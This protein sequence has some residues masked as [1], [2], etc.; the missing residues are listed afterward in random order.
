M[1]A[2]L[3]F[4]RPVQ[5][6]T[7]QIENSSHPWFNLFGG[8]R[9]TSSGQV[10]TPSGSM[11]SAAV[12]LCVTFL[13]KLMASLAIE[14]AEEHEHG[15]TILP[16][17]PIAKLLK[18]K[19]NP[20]MTIYDFISLGM[21]N[22]A[23]NGN[24]YAELVYDGQ[25]EVKEIWPVHPD[26]LTI[27]R[28]DGHLIYVVRS[29]DG[30]VP[31]RQD[32]MIHIKWHSNDGINGISPIQHASEVV[33]H[34]LALQEYGSSLMANDA[35]PPLMIEVPVGLDDSSMENAKELLAS[36]ANRGTGKNRHRAGML[37]PGMKLHQLSISNEQVQ[38]LQSRQYTD[39]LI[40]ALFG[41]PSVYL[42][43]S[44]KDT[45]ASSNQKELDLRKYTLGP[46]ARN[47]ELE[48]TTKLFPNSNL[49]AR[50]N[51][52]SLLRADEKTR[53]EINQTAIQNGW[54]S[55]NEVRMREGENPVEGLDYYNNTKQADTIIPGE[56]QPSVDAVAE[57]PV[58]DT[59]SERTTPAIDASIY[60]P[61]VLDAVN[62][63]LTK[64][65]RQIRSAVK[66]HSND[67]D[68]F[69]SWVGKHYGDDQTTQHDLTQALSAIISS[70][71]AKG[72][73]LVDAD[74]AT[75]WA[76]SSKGQLMAVVRKNSDWKSAVNDCLNDWEA[77][78]VSNILDIFAKPIETI[79]TTQEQ[80]EERT[81]VNVT[82]NMPE[83]TINVATPPAPNVTVE[84]KQ[85]DVVVNV[86]EQ[87]AP[88]INVMPA[89]A[90]VEN[91]VNV[92]PVITVEG[93][94][95]VTD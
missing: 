9:Q 26:Q 61:M 42:N 59:L 28:I 40:C 18:Y 46:L 67:S 51:F 56:A 25:G 86:P 13:S 87:P 14:V 4:G 69:K 12:Y 65:I 63:V 62:R 78:R 10:V 54:R 55:P 8:G 34:G 92:Q 37:L 80:D 60:Q 36:F 68:A 41:V 33:G 90:K 21:N 73:Q 43:D 84:N 20:E 22:L 48:L 82:I 50:F 94:A 39:R 44:I 76:S 83:Q 89:D 3:L 15:T 7:A 27:R 95:E 30:T 45:F 31:L 70:A 88:T 6:A 49:L 23:L 32:E 24:F 81:T 11:Q 77:E 74:F 38:F 16:N 52:A 35:T 71:S 75:K 17:H 91:T 1:I 19:P 66:R 64:E 85:A 72:V 5:Q 57:V 58:I 93:D 53:A 47:W 2:E 29:S 79:E